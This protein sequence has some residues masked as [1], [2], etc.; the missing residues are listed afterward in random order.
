MSVAMMP[1]KIGD[2]PIVII[3]KEHKFAHSSPDPNIPS[4]ARTSVWRLQHTK[5]TLWLQAIQKLSRAVG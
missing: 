3:E 2:N 1:E 5:S 4:R